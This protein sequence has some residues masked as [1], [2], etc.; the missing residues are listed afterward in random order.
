MGH[1]LEG[2]AG[3]SPHLAEQVEHQ[4][5]RDYDQYL[6]ALAGA[7]A[8]LVPLADDPFNACKSAVR[9][10]DAAAV[11]RPVIASP[12]GDL[13]HAVVPGETGWLAQRPDDWAAALR[14]LAALPDRGRSMGLA[15]RQALQRDLSAPEA[16][17]VTDPGLLAWLAT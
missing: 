13:A 7:D 8:V 5:F 6:A 16:A 12:V 14:A 10:L 3:L 1:G 9:V 11:A 17:G 2:H 15:A 4:P